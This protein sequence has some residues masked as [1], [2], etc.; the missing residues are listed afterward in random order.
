MINKAIL[1]KKI[2]ACLNLVIKT[3]ISHKESLSKF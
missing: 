1:V 3:S 2:V